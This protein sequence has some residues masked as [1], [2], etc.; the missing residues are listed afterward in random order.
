MSRDMAAAAREAPTKRRVRKFDSLSA[1]TEGPTT[2]ILRLVLR[3]V[4]GGAKRDLECGVQ[5][6]TNA[7]GAHKQA[8]TRRFAQGV[9]PRAAENRLQGPVCARHSSAHRGCDS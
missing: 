1:A 4:N 7:R 5:E 3:C 9:L 8:E 6:F 2:S